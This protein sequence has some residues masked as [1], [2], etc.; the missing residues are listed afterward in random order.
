MNSRY[1]PNGPTESCLAQ[2]S[3]ETLEQLGTE[4][5]HPLAVQPAQLQHLKY[6][7]IKC[8]PLSFLTVGDKLFSLIKFIGYIP[9]WVTICII[10]TLLNF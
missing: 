2:G 3:E 10:C 8:M 5:H 9:T 1:L 4:H 6:Q 7:L